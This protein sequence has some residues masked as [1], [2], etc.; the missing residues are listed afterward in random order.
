MSE[1]WRDIPGYEN[2]YQVSNL[3]RVRS[4]D[5]V[6]GNG[7]WRKGA[8]IELNPVYWQAAVQYLKEAEIK[9]SAPTLFDLLAEQGM[10]AD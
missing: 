3:G 4:L 2:L 5:R 6:D 9:A 1:L 7:D 8:C 10:A